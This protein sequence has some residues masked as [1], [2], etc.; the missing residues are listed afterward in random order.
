VAA[1]L[2]PHARTVRTSMTSHEV[3]PDPKHTAAWSAVGGVVTIAASSATLTLAREPA[4]AHV[5]SWLVYACGALT[6][7]GIYLMIAPLAHWWPWSSGV[8]PARDNRRPGGG[9]QRH[10][11]LTGGL[12]VAASIAAA[13]VA[14]APGGSNKLATV[15]RLNLDAETAARP[16]S[17]RTGVHSLSHPRGC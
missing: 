13:L 4:T 12:L 9:S 14:L 5:S 1:I 16:G 6:L 17:L 11:R 2:P 3:D 7:I 8:K 10:A 15:G